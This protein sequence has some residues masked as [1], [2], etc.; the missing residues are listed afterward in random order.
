MPLVPETHALYFRYKEQ[1]DNNYTLMVAV[2]KGS[3]F[4]AC[5]VFTFAN[6]I[7]HDD[8]VDTFDVNNYT[9]HGVQG[10]TTAHNKI[11]KQLGVY[12]LTHG[13]VW[14]RKHEY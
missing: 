11:T 13:Q 9:K 14:P 8:G 5:Q 2:Q 12:E 7:I 1:A 4:P 10:N 6:Q 3:T